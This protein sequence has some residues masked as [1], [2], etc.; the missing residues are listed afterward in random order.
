MALLIAGVVFWSVTHLFPATAPG[1]RTSLVGK[2]GLGPYKGLFALDIVLA[3]ALIVYGWKTAAPTSLYVPPLYGSPLPSA[4]ILIA[5]VLLVASSM[6]NNLKRLI[7][8]PQMTA[9][10]FWGGGHL[11]TNGDSRS[12]ILFGGLVVWAVLEMFFINR[13]D[14]QWRK[15]DRV[16]V[17]KDVVMVLIGAAAT[18]IVIYFHTSLFGVPAIII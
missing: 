10:V 14:G 6:P 8:H 3:L 1:V 11:L 4:L 13:R 2:L 16:A 9:V 17:T 5:M 15:P 18:A 7:R 12:T